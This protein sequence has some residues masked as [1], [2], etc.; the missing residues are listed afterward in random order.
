MKIAA[1]EAD[2]TDY[3]FT[4]CQRSKNYL[5]NESLHQDLIEIIRII[6]KIISSSKNRT[7]D[8]I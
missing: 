7:P 3:W 1:K 2:E 8:N 5:Y 4:L 6:S